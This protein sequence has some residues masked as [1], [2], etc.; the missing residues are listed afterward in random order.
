MTAKE[1]DVGSL[2]HWDLSNVYPG[3]ESKEFKTAVEQVKAQLDDLDSY[4]SESNIRR[5][6]S[7]PES[8]AKLAETISHYLDRMNDLLLLFGTLE[9]YVHSFVSTDSY[10]TTAK[11]VESELEV[12]GVRLERLGVFFE[13]WMRMVTEDPNA[14]PAALEHEGSAKEH[15]FYLKETAE[16]SKYMMSEAEE[17]LASELSLSGAVAWAKLQGV[18]SSQIKVPFER[19]GR[20]QELP[21]TVIINLRTDPDED[22]RRRAYEVEQEAWERVR[23][24][25]AA[26]LN[27]VKGSVIT[28]YK[29][30]GRTDPLHQTLDQ[31]R[32][33]RETLETLLGAMRGSFPMFRRY[34]HAKAER[35]GKSALPWWD[36]WAPVGR[37]ERRYS[38][39]EARGFVLGQ[40][41]T[42]SDRLAEFAHHAYESS[43]I[44]AEP[45]DGKRAGAFC[46]TLP[47]VKESRVLC[48]FDGS[49]EQVTTI[50]HELGHAYHNEMQKN[51]T[52]LQRRTPMTLAETASIF[53]QAIVTDAALAQAQSVDE[54]LAI[55]ETDLIDGSQVIV[56]IYSRYLFENEVFQRR[57]QSELSADDFCESMS[58]AQKETYA[59][60]LDPEHL[61]PYMWTWKPHYYIPS[62]SFYNF[63]YAFGLLFG[64]GLYAI[65][66]QRGSD[67]LD[68]YD[69]LLSSTGEGTAADLA[70]RFDINLKEPAFW[71]GSLKV[72]EG[73]IDRYV[74]L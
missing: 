50:A 56:D 25:L 40:F 12:L 44:D 37:L 64:L 63:P 58:R 20:T 72:I 22:V 10:N 29:R 52:P 24:P 55:L 48:N 9:A 71:E 26:C 2:P 67:F 69:A 39:D 47:A 74:A 19:E 59:E 66:Q 51:K 61:H 45:R 5:A 1:S 21:I 18:V 8:S 15:A 49:P 31:A 27:G 35:L 38:W 65:Y 13:G 68:E 28:L 60:A 43:W 7:R 54:E 36:L 6:G 17:T 62:L 23:E 32:I 14:L 11:R 53:T 42:F 46:M 41:D 73:R 16:Q 33:D 34:W 57:E 3:L 70:A 4:M 30:R